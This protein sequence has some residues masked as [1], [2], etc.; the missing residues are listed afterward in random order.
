M[1]L[2][3]FAHEHLG[4]INAEELSKSDKVRSFVLVSS[5]YQS[6]INAS[7]SS[8]SSEIMREVFIYY[9]VVLILKVILFSFLA[10]G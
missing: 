9:P 8:Y 7:Y 10:Y 5:L 2:S 1:L 4:T 6:K 3:T